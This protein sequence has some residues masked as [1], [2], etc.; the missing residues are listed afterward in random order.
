MSRCG[1]I[2]SD[3]SLLRTQSVENH[4][5]SMV[6]SNFST[7]RHGR[8]K[9]AW[10]GLLFKPRPYIFRDYIRGKGEGGSG[11][12][13]FRPP[14]SGAR[15]VAAKWQFPIKLA[16]SQRPRRTHS[17]RVKSVPYASFR[18]PLGLAPPPYRSRSA[19]PHPTRYIPAAT[20]DV[21]GVTCA[22]ALGVHSVPPGPAPLSAPLWSFLVS[23]ARRAASSAD[24]RFIHAAWF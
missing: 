11:L 17:A 9:R 21:S 23:R 13:D 1:E 6:L 7:T 20:A 19:G 8:A 4:E 10:L 3:R 5:K 2:R 16:V 24:W 14:S 12:L 15:R 22:R 18:A